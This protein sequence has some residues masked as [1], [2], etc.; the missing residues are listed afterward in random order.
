MKILTEGRIAPVKNYEVL[1]RAAKIL[2]RRGIN[3]S[4]T[5]VGEA[6]LPQDKVY[7]A[8]MRQES[9]GLPITFLGKVLFRNLPDLYRAHDMFVHMSKTGSLDK[10]LLAAM[11]C[12]LTVISC[13]DAARA[14][15]PPERIF[16]PDD[17]ESLA[18]II[19]NPRAE[20]FDARA[21]VVRHHDLKRLIKFISEKL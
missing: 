1:I 9:R 21:Y 7:E 6:V 4:I 8:R 14:F 12:D 20:D 11:A 18:E 17:A 2:K 3:F 13:N 19:V 10:V 15:L 5:V 16:S